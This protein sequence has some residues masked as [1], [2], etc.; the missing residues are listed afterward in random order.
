[1]LINRVARQL[2][3][4]PELLPA[5]SELRAGRDATVAVS[6]SAR[7]LVLASAWAADPRPCLFVVSGE[8]AAER[9]AHALEAWL[10]KDVVLRYPERH[11]L[12]WK[13][14]APDDAVI[15]ART[16]AIGRLATPGCAMGSASTIKRR[17]T[18][19]VFG[20][21]LGILSLSASA[22]RLYRKP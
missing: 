3:G 9:A 22:W 15:G 4:A 14:D 16:E 11:D 6:Q 5:L 20:A 18:N 21:V 17:F 12:P 7:A 13:S 19:A 8:E 2:L 10:G 1:M